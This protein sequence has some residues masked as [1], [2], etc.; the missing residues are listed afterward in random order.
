[1]PRGIPN[2]LMLADNRAKKL[3]PRILP[4]PAEAVR[5]YEEHGGHLTEEG[6]FGRDPLANDAEKCRIRETAFMDRY[7][8]AFHNI[9]NGNDTLFR[10]ELKY[11]IDITYRLSAS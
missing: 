9:V 3:D 11:F 6:H 2:Q 1:M 4:T 7:P 5:M 8:S 10:E